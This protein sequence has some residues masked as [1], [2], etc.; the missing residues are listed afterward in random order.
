MKDSVDTQLR[1]QQVGIR[2]DRLCTDQI[3]TLR[4]I[5]RQSIEW[6]SSPYI[7]FLDYE[8][9]FYSMDRTTL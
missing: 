6:N 2:K 4:I 1:D 3:T 7:N 8:K 9:A 5:V